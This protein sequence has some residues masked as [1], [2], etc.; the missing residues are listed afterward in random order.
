M[1]T[2]DHDKL[3]DSDYQVNIA[4]WTEK[5]DYRRNWLWLQYKRITN[6]IKNLIWE[7]WDDSLITMDQSLQKDVLDFIETVDAIYNNELTA[8]LIDYNNGFDAWW[9]NESAATDTLEEEFNC[10]N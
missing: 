5:P 6:N 10:N 9:F 4:S 7:V 2:D 3:S 1:V 8:N